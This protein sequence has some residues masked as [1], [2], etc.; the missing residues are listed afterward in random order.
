MRFLEYLQPG[1]LYAS[2][3]DRWPGLHLFGLL[4][5]SFVVSLFKKSIHFLEIPENDEPSGDKPEAENSEIHIFLENKRYPRGGES[6][7]RTVIPQ[8][9]T[10][11]A[12]GAASN[13]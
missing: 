6:S 12:T 2:V 13:G 8:A 7:E 9:D 4:R 10:S 5:L 11:R 3:N 1:P